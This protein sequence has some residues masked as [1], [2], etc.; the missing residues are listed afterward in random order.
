MLLNFVV[1]FENP[2]ATKWE[3]KDTIGW[4]GRQKA[5]SWSSVQRRSH[6]ETADGKRYLEAGRRIKSERGQAEATNLKLK[7]EVRDH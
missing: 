6:Q 3:C 1:Y 5:A 7:S 2:N 4:E